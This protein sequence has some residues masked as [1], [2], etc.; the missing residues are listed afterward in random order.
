[1]A[2]KSLSQMILHMGVAFMRIRRRLAARKREVS[3]A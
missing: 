3:P 1:M 2:A